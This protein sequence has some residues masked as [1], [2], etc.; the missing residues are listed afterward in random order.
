MFSG[1]LDFPS[2]PKQ[3]MEQVEAVLECLADITDLE[4]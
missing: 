3:I 2:S 4:C 1:V